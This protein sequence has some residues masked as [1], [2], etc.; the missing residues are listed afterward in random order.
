MVNRIEGCAGMKS[1]KQRHLLPIY[2]K[3]NV[4][5]DLGKRSLR[6]PTAIPEAA[7]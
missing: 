2:V 7:R 4:I 5:D 1:Y 3:R 6:M